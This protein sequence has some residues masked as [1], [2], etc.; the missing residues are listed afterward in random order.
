M[1]TGRVLLRYRNFLF[2]AGC[3]ERK[4]I[5]NWNPGRFLVIYPQFTDRSLQYRACKARPES[6]GWM[7]VGPRG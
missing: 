5:L 3:G 2:P 6:G 7:L 1:R 4:P